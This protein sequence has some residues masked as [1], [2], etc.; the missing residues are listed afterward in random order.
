MSCWQFIDQERSSYPVELL[1]RT[2]NVSPARYYAWRTR[3]PPNPVRPAAPDW[4]QALKDT[5]GQHKRCY[6][7]RRLRVKLQA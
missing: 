5:F 1:Y 4:E 3:Q 7:T 2:L 6:G